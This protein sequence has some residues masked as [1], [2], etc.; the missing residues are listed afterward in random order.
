MKIVQIFLAIFFSIAVAACGGGGSSDGGGGGGG[1][2]ITTIGTMPYSGSFTGLNDS[3]YKYTTV[4]TVNTISATALTSDIDPKVYTDANFTTIS[5]NWVCSVNSGAAADSCTA[6]TSVP[7]GTVLY[8]KARNY[9]GTSGTFTL[10]VSGPAGSPPTITSFTP[11]SGAPGSTVTISGTNFSATAANNSANFNGITASVTGATTTSLT[12]TVPA[13]ASTGPITVTTAAGTA[14]SVASFTVSSGGGTTTIASMPYNGS[15]TG[16]NH[17]FYKYTTVGTVST[18]SATALTNDIDLYVYTDA[19]FTTLSSNWSCPYHLGTAAESCT[20]TTPV[21]AGTVLYIKAVNYTGSAGASFTLSV[22]GSSG[23]TYTTITPMP[24]NGSV[25]GTNHGYYKYTTVGTVGTISAT[26]LTNDI[27]L[28]VYT[29][30]TFT[31]LS[32]NWSC[33]Y[34]TGTAAESCTATTAVPS[35]TVLYIKAEN[36]TGGTGASFTLSVAGSGGGG[37]GTTLTLSFGN[38]TGLTYNASLSDSATAAPTSYSR[39]WTNAAGD[40]L[41]L[42]YQVSATEQVLSVAIGS[43]ANFYWAGTPT[44]NIICH[45]SGTNPGWPTC[46]SWGITVSRA[47]GTI[48][49]ANTPVFN[50]SSYATGTMSGSFSFTAF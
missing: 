49:F 34:H 13:T 1:F 8:I 27:D 26:A 38:V 31:T 30:A 44:V 16:A 12:V 17:G 47:A 22:A 10:S 32:S 15:V 3:Y 24:Y 14:T 42:V 46:A 39:V 37:S 9:A 33:P 19:T 6:T 11:S 18:I 4:G 40:M 43:G 2:S 35:G 36:W 25:T 45:V 41:D 23:T 5:S 7:A 28:Y 50:D 29:D 48:S 21:S 20:A